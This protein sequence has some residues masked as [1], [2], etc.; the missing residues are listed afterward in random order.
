MGSPPPSLHPQIR[1]LVV[2]T[3]FGRTLAKQMGLSSGLCTKALM[4]VQPLVYTCHAM[5]CPMLVRD[6]EQ[7]IFRW[8]YM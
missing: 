7:T 5:S 8:M 1:V 3:S 2:C 4:T 6:R